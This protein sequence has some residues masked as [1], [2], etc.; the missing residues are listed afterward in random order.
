MV[1]R[2]HDFRQ[3]RYVNILALLR[4]F[5]AFSV[6]PNCQAAGGRVP[7]IAGS[8]SPGRYVRQPGSSAGYRTAVVVAMGEMG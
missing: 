2:L 4:Q 7:A 8:R 6:R 5:L 3:H 1:K